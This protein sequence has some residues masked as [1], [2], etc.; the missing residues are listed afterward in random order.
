MTKSNFNLLKTLCV[1]FV[2]FVAGTAAGESGKVRIVV[3]NVRSD[4]GNLAV[5]LFP[6]ESAKDFPKNPK[7]AVASKLVSAVKGETVIEL[8]GVAP[9][10]YAVSLLHDE[11]RD[12]KMNFNLVGMPKEGFGFSRDPRIYFGA[13][14]FSKCEVEVA[15]PETDVQVTAKYF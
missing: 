12:G 15:A 11:N 5:A 14:D 3:K 13:P 6:K 7:L 10:L 4:A 8:E 1:V 2:V 9:G